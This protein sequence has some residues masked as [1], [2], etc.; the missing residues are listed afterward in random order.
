M[1]R[2]RQPEVSNHNGWENNATMENLVLSGIFYLRPVAPSIQKEA[3]GIF[4]IQD[5]AWCI[6]TFIPQ[7]E[8]GVG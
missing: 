8:S 5:G 2:G 7:E 4:P 1:D 3:P 6:A